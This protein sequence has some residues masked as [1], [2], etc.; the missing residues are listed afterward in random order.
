MLARCE[1]G[2]FAGAVSGGGPW[3]SGPGRVGD[4]SVSG[5]ALYAGAKGVVF[6][7]GHSEAILERSLTRTTSYKLAS[8]GSANAALDWAFEDA[9]KGELSVT[10]VDGRS[11][12]VAPAN[13]TAW[14]A[15]DPE[16]RSS[17]ELAP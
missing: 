9:A 10:I 7:R 8:S 15:K 16:L 5:A 17:K 3:L 2:E 14:A 13:S 4:V 1:N 11:V 6:V 12:T